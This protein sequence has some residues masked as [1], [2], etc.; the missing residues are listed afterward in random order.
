MR[1]V[2][3]I[4][5]EGSTAA[6]F[7]GDVRRR[8][9]RTAPP[10]GLA[11]PTSPPAA[12]PAPTPARMA[13]S[14]A[15]SS[16][17]QGALVTGAQQ[18]QATSSSS[19]PAAA[20]ATAAVPSAA[21]ATGHHPRPTSQ[22]LLTLFPVLKF[23]RGFSVTLMGMIP[24]AGTAFLVFGRTKNLLHAYFATSRDQDPDRYTPSKTVLDLFAGCIAGAISQTAA[25]PFEVIRR[26]QQIGGKTRPDALV[27]M[28][29]TARWIYRTS[30]IRGFYVGLSIGLLKVMPMSGVRYVY[31]GSHEFFVAF[32][33]GWLID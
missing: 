19:T 1:I 24:Y 6:P 7:S 11:N 32:S 20:T 9:G 18:A 21:T 17:N 22:R 33:F 13:F 5:T 14:A 4:Y 15:T 25:Y 3:T 27:G 2:R 23:Y 28:E 30:G 12:T 16:L 31:F 10:S 29:E 26:C 8:G